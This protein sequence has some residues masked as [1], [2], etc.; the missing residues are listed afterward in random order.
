MWSEPRRKLELTWCHA[1]LFKV[2][3]SFGQNIDFDSINGFWVV[4]VRLLLF[5][6]IFLYETFTWLVI[7]CH[8]VMMIGDISPE[9]GANVCALALTLV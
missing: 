6:Y 1:L 5:Y 4:H 9:E 7:T 2:D 3:T 8:C